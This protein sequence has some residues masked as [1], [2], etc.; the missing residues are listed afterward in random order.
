MVGDDRISI[1]GDAL[2]STDVDKLIRAIS[3][4]GKA[5]IQTLHKETGIDKKM[6]DKWVRVLE[7][8]GYVKLEYR[9]MNTLVTWMGGFSQEKSTVLVQPVQKE[10][11]LVGNGF[12]KQTSQQN[13]SSNYTDEKREDRF[14]E[15]NEPALFSEDPL[16]DILPQEVRE[17]KEDESGI[18]FQEDVSSDTILDVESPA[19]FELVPPQEK[20]LTRP[21]KTFINR[22]SKELLN[23]YL[24]AITDQ[25]S[26]IESLKKEKERLYRTTFMD[27]EQQFEGD[28]SSITEKILEKESRILEL[29]ERVLSLP[30][31]VEEVERLT[32]TMQ[33]IH[34]EG[35][36]AL[37]A[38]REKARAFLDVIKNS[39]N[40][41][42]QQLEESK[43][44]LE[45]ERNTI[46]ELNAARVSIEDEIN[47]TT[48]RIEEAKSLLEK[49]TQTMQTLT[50][51]IEDALHRKDEAQTVTEDLNQSVKSRHEQLEALK[52][53]LDTIKSVESKVLS[54]IDDYE[55]K[56]T[57]IESYVQNSEE[58]L[59]RLR[60]SAEGAYIHTYVKELESL[61]D[62]Y[63]SEVESASA[64]GK[65]IDQQIAQAREKLNGLLAE[66]KTMIQK[67]HSET[68]Q[69]AD[70][71]ATARLLRQRSEKMKK[72][73]HYEKKLP[74]EEEQKEIQPRLP[75]K[76]KGKKK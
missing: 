31:Q 53:E 44:I 49:V 30:D 4:K 2:I 54:Y 56:I 15:K 34:E 42:A 64:Q 41:V 38:A 66:S 43:S 52:Q 39:E 5:D 48:L 62:Q 16:Q 18:P 71:D 69:L 51:D 21:E 26:E 47:Q 35:R 72:A 17:G 24:D 6:I 36:T 8:E 67:M 73:L 9:F 76:K 29:K 63:G 20:P 19:P 14:V 25:K 70:F 37:H 61:V 59:D 60:E 22:K 1:G 57:D 11:P 12:H 74:V 27:L 33:K 68:D 58:E 50:T 23:E 45:L 7:D 40:E 13:G 3:A 28:I 65:D 46:E 10:P 32:E 55:A 75:K